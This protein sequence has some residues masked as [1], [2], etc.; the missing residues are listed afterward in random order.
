MATFDFNDGIQETVSGSDP[1]ISFTD[2]GVDFTLSSAASNLG[3]EVLNYQP[4]FGAFS[5]TDSTTV[6]GV[7]L[8][9]SDGAGNNVFQGA[10]TLN[11]SIA[12][13]PGNV[14]FVATDPADNV[15]VPMTVG[16]VSTGPTTAN[17]TGIILSGGY[18]GIDSMTT[19]ADSLTC[20]LTGTKIAT[21]EGE[22]AVEDIKAGDLIRTVDGV[23]RVEWLGVQSVDVT[24]SD[25]AK[26]NPICFSK[27]CM[28]E[29]MPSRDLY[30]SPNHAVEFDGHLYDAHTLV[31][32]RSIYQVA[33]PGAE[34]TYYHIET[35]AHELLLAENMPAE[36]FVDFADRGN[37]D[38]GS[39]RL[40]APLIP[41]MAAPRISAKR[42]VPSATT[43][44]LAARAD[45]LG[46]TDKMNRAA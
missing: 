1:T 4:A 12:F 15:V 42:M 31:N 28:G 9:F 46:L 25:P 43:A 44:K 17:F 26:V 24:T 36:T 14:T 20:F 35:G 39:D 2:N 23:A 41:E 22:V 18:Y 30:L 29:G 33:K 8:S 5:V 10:I 7:T 34:F 6:G 45:A 3:D 13:G 37:F 40:D 19:T 27:G 16:A 32:G 38:N 11:V 21:P